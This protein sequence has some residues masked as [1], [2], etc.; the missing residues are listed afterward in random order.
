VGNIA[1]PVDNY[2]RQKGS[3]ANS[4]GRSGKVIP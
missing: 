3:V 2:S 4:A 1:S